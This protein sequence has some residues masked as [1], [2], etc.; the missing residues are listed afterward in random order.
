MDWL[1][2]TVVLCFGMSLVSAGSLSAQATRERQVADVQIEGLET[3]SS[4]TLHRSLAMLPEIYEVS[5]PSIDRATYVY[6]VHE[7]VKRGMLASGFFDATVE[8][9]PGIEPL[10]LLVDEGPRIRCGSI[11]VSGGTTVVN[12]WVESQLQI[13]ST[14][15]DAKPVWRRGKPAVGSLFGSL[16]HRNKIQERLNEIGLQGSRSSIDFYRNDQTSEQELRVQLA[17][18]DASFMLPGAEKS[19]AEKS[20][21]EKSETIESEFGSTSRTLLNQ[22]AEPT[23]PAGVAQELVSIHQRL[24]AKPNAGVRFRQIEAGIE[25][26]LWI[27]EQVTVAK[28]TIGS[29]VRHFVWRDSELLIS[30]AEPPAAICL[31]V[32]NTTIILTQQSAAES[33]DGKTTSFTLGGSLSSKQQEQTAQ[34][35]VVFTAQAWA[36]WFPPDETTRTT[37]EHGVTYIHQDHRLRLDHTGSLIEL[38]GLDASDRQLQYSAVIDSEI[39]SIAD[40]FLGA[41]EPLELFV[42]DPQ[43]GEHA[44]L[45]DVF[46]RVTKNEANKDDFHIPP[47]NGNRDAIGVMLLLA[48]NDGR[49]MDPDSVLTQLG[50]LYA[51]ELSGNRRGLKERIKSLE[52]E[53]M[54]GPLLS[55]ALAELLE[56]HGN[57]ERSLQLYRH[58]QQL[59]SEPTAVQPEIQLLVSQYNLIGRMCEEV[60]VKEWL[61]QTT[62]LAAP[63]LKGEMAT[64]A[65]GFIDQLPDAT[66]REQ[67]RS[68]AGRVL[69]L[70]YQIRGQAI[71]GQYVAR[72]ITVLEAA[73]Q[74][75]AK[76]KESKNEKKSKR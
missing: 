43:S 14:E 48:T 31:P 16:A 56:M 30:M 74:R 37:D 2:R 73:Q 33:K 53:A 23:G 20:G 64:V 67:R 11:S 52:P 32:P 54:Q 26:E 15:E 46:N 60:D 40:G 75:L 65:Q 76:K 19:G 72:K 5:H 70:A 51:L 69:V 28:L 6:R 35:G 42:R 18:E 34:M 71:L 13:A 62:Q 1:P 4:A 57:K 29:H 36:D 44:T 17:A 39:Q 58:S 21:A 68:N 25:V 27:G 7:A 59:L 8:V 24:F 10:K 50:K 45:H 47:A 3:I 41:V 55:L 9:V 38:V 12:Q 61:Q 63:L 49:L 22:S 66:T